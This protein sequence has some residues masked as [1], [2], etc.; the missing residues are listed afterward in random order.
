MYRMTQMDFQGRI[1]VVFCHLN[2]L[3]LYKALVYF[4]Q[5]KNKADRKILHFILP[6]LHR[7][8]LTG[9]AEFKVS[10]LSQSKFPELASCSQPISCQESALAL[11]P[12]I[13]L[14]SKKTPAESVLFK[15]I[16]KDFLSQRKNNSIICTVHCTGQKRC[17]S[18][19]SPR[20]INIVSLD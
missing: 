7:V 9:S 18:V 11:L 19:P 14:D 3:I 13:S 5:K 10:V 2:L 16:I 17:S 12:Q 8:I 15:E 20:T 1:H 4:T 6:Q